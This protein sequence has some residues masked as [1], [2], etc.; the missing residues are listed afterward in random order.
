MGIV[1]GLLRE[2]FSRWQE[3]K[4]GR[5]AAAL[6]FYT[7]FSLSP[8][9]ILVIAVVS[10]VWD[11]AAVE[12]QIIGQIEGLVGEQSADFIAGM[13]ERRSSTG[14]GLLGTIVGVVTLLLGATGALAQLKAAMNRV[15]NVTDTP[16]EGLRAVVRSRRSFSRRSSRS[17]PTSTLPGETWRSGRS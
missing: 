8:L 17:F 15:W 14:S 9:L 1:L 16:L 3:D 4:A 11:Q 7:V 5:L 6:S 12:G 10:L 2:T 13:M